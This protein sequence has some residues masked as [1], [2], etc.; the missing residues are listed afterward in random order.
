MN[1]LVHKQLFKYLKLNNILNDAQSG[2]H[3]H[4]FA[5]IVLRNC[6]RHFSLLMDQS[7]F[8]GALFITLSKSLLT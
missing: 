5:V 6:W 4:Y 2:F 7:L 3:S 8:I 1:K